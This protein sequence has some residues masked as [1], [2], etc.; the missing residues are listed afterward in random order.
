MKKRQWNIR[1]STTEIPDAQRRWDRAYQQLLQGSA[2]P[3]P[4]STQ[5]TQHQENH[6]EHRGLRPRFDTKTSTSTDNRTAT[7]EFENIS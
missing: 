1:R 2:V 4:L 5:E 3:V 7:R 6:Y